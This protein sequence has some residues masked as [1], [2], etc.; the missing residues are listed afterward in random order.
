MLNTAPEN[1]NQCADRDNLEIR[2][3]EKGIV[4]KGGMGIH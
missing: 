4:V 2:E 3:L 1:I